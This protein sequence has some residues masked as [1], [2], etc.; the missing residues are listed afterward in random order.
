M[1]RRLLTIIIFSLCLTAHTAHAGGQITIAAAADL[2]FAMDEIVDLFGKSH[3]DDQVTCLYGSSGK[4]QTQIRQGAPYDLYFSADI[5]Y[6]VALK[7][8]GLASGDVRPYARGR[9]VLWSVSRKFNQLSDLTDSAIH[10]IAIANPGHAP[11]G[12]R[13]EEALNAAGVWNK[14]ESRLI[15]GENVAQTVQFVQTGNADVGIIAMSLARSAELSK[16]GHYALIPES[17][18]SPL[19]QGFM[20][21]RR[22]ANNPTAQNFAQFMTSPAVRGIMIRYGFS[23]PEDAR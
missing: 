6:P 1:T 17:L 11:Y 9:I 2:K 5:A 10:K 13:A 15:F 20:L 14:V 22:A 18:H 7:N 16:S 19:D 12:K 8:E 4:F 3:P 23:L 21:T